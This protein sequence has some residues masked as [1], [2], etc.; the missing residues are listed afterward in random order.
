[1]TESYLKDPKIMIDHDQAYL[2]KA[3]KIHVFYH[4]KLHMNEISPY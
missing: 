1:M 3:K 2:H 4:I